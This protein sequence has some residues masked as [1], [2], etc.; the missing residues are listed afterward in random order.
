MFLIAMVSRGGMGGGGDIKFMALVGSF[1]GVPGGLASFAIACITGGAI[2]GVILMALGIKSR[3]RRDSV[4]AV[5]ILRDDHY[6]CFQRTG[7]FPGFPVARAL[8]KG[9]DSLEEDVF[10]RPLQADYRA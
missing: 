1:L 6:M 9:G 7:Y 10:A 5:H 2:A 3:E 4:R 8:K